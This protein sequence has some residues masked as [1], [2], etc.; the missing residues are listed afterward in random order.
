[1]PECSVTYSF[2]RFL[3]TISNDRLVHAACMTTVLTFF[4]DDSLRYVQPNFSRI[5][6]LATSPDIIVHD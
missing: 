1:M 4:V 5:L 6:E 3:C 2:Y